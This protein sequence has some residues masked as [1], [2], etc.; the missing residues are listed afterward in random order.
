MKITITGISGFVGQNLSTY[1]ENRDCNIHGLS[2]RLSKWNNNFVSN[3][4][5]IIHLAGKAHDTS[6]TSFDTEYFKVN[7][8][9]TIKLYEEFLHSDVKDFFYFSSVKAAADIV[10]TSLTEDVEAKPQTPYG[11]S[12]LEAEKYILS[13][14]IPSGKRVFIIRPCMIHGPGNK[15]NLNLLYNVVEKGVPWPLASFENQ[16]SFLSIDNL[17]YLIYEML[18]N[19]NLQSGVYNFADD[20]AVSTNDLVRIIGSVLHKEVS[21][22][23]IPARLLSS[24]VKIGDFIPLPLNSERLKKLTESYV[25]S[26]AKI[27]KSLGIEKLPLSAKEG[28]L[29]TIKSFNQAK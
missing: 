3:V 24:V 4:D 10:E 22:W 1:L 19:S 14:Q 28:L 18:K 26:N 27:K 20:D 11:K 5:A 12:K 17:S 13:K 29:I 25:V 7:R 9:L 16:R 21:L 8:D 15:G 23:K 6:N 2:L